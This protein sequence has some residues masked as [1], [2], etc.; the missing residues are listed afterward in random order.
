MNPWQRPAGCVATAMAAATAGAIVAF[1]LLAAAPAEAHEFWLAPTA[2][3]AAVGDTVA[4]SVF[5]GTGFRGELKPWAAPRARRFTLHGP[6][7]IDLRPVTMNGDVTWARFVAPDAG[8]AL[9]AY[10]SDWADI[11]LPAA[12][13]DSYLALEGLDAPLAARRRIGAAAGPGRER[14][15]R[16]PKC[17]I[18]GDRPARASTVE[19]LPLELV[20]L[21]DPCASRTLAVRVLYRGQPLAGALVRGWNHPL[22]RGMAPVDAAARD[23]VGPSASTRTGADGIARLELARAGEWMLSC[24]HMVASEDPHEADWQS[25]WASLTFARTEPVK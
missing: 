4:L 1:A 10:A 21:S 9:I 18:A 8:G 13:F 14:Y 16:C 5:V 3:R 7:V 25:L 24:V 22:G 6:R 12:E 19:G 11:T 20:P 23:S 15:A 17:W 2:F